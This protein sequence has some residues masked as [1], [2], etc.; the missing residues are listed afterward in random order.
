MLNS[1]I[2]IALHHLMFQLKKYFDRIYMDKAIEKKWEKVL[3]HEDYVLW[4]YSHWMIEKMKFCDT[5]N[6]NLKA[7][8]PGTKQF[9]AFWYY[10]IQKYYGEPAGPHVL[11][12]LDLDYQE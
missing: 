4:D 11:K 6:H 1:E 7:F 5:F 10:Q 9:K 2:E 3:K 12:I 8:W